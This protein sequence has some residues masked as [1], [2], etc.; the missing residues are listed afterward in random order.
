MTTMP[1]QNIWRNM[2]GY[3]Y[4]SIFSNIPKCTH[5]TVNQSLSHPQSY[6]TWSWRPDT[7]NRNQSFDLSLHEMNSFRLTPVYLTHTTTTTAEQVFKLAAVWN[8]KACADLVF[9]HPSTKWKPNP[10]LA[11]ESRMD[12][13]DLHVYMLWCLSG[14]RVVTKPKVECWSG[15][16]HTM[17]SD[18]LV[19]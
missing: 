19:V 6:F 15:S 8:A 10:G 9:P 13:A 18:G 1:I 3:W 17:I 7:F 12:A 4:F 16:R 5:I 11:Q 14:Y 2:C